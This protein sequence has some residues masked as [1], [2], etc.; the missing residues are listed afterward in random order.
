MGKN[1][2]LSD[3][4]L[5]LMELFWQTTTP[6]SFKEIL[7][8]CNEHLNKNWKKQTLN[9]Y[10][11]N[12]VK[13]GLLSVCTESR[14]HTYA[15]SCT[16]DELRK[17]WTKSLVRD[18]FDNSIGKFVASFTGGKKLTEEEKEELKKLL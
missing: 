6:L 8:Y 11:S 7:D 3:T 18:H 16:K 10:L 9:T 17:N 4:E 13:S 15:A 5:E 2:G 14:H 12:M 1:F